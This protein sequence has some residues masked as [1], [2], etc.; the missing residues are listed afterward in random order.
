MNETH[1]RA[2]IHPSIA[3][4]KSIETLRVLR[5]DVH[6]YIDRDIDRSMENELEKRPMMVA[7]IDRVG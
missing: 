4:T 7:K 2:F 5:F 3:R 6:R 1:R